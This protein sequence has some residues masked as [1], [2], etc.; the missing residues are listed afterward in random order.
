[1]S[2]RKPSPPRQLTPDAAERAEEVSRLR[3]HGAAVKVDK[4]GRV[5]SAYRSNVFN[6][7]LERRS[8]TQ[9]HHDAAHRL[10]EQWA[11]WKG[12]D[13]GG[14]QGSERVDGGT[15]C[16]PKSLVTDR[17]LMAGKWVDNVLRQIPAD[18]RRIL[19]ALVIATVE[20]D[21]PMAWRGIVQRT[22]GEEVRDRQT[23]SV[24]LAL[25]SLRETLEAAKTQNLVAA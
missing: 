16:G 3:K 21:R 20:E 1:M 14:E 15:S 9:N 13:A 2:R 7:L 18:E 4:I 5:I 25:E 17:M 22:T 6:L 8:I 23:A 11:A 24:V 10:C 19:T 12:L